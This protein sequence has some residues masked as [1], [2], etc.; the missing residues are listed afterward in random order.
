MG[1]PLT[2]ILL[3]THYHLAMRTPEPNLVSGRS[4]FQNAVTR[5][6]DVRNQLWGHLFGGRY[7]AVA[8]EGTSDPPNKRRSRAALETELDD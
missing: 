1:D 7:K 3:D 2:W 6:I 4:W 5:Q 8:V